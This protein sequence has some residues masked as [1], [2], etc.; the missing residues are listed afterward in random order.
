MTI[1]S[2]P[3]DQIRMIAYSDASF[4]TRD[5]QHSQKGMLILA[6]HQD[7]FQQK[8]ALASPI[9]WSSKKIERVVASTLAAETY[10]LSY[11]VDTLNW[12]RL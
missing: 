3:E 10:A 6:A 1:S 11:T 4:A 7:V 5:K 12:V 2:I 9:S 8:I